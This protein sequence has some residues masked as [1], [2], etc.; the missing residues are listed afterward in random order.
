MINKFKKTI[1]II[2]RTRNESR[3]I[4]ACLRSIRSQEIDMNIEIILV[5]NKSSDKTLEL[6]QPFVDKVCKIEKYRAR[7]LT[8]I[9]LMYFFMGLLPTF[10]C[11]KPC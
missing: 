4:R 7:I 9:L 1:S 2:V 6:S 5:D 3:W 8:N 11:E 10:T